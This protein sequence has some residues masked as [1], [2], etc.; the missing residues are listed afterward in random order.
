M[1][2]PQFMIV[3]ILLMFITTVGITVFLV[4]RSNGNAR[5][6][7]FI[8]CVIASFYLIGYLIAPVSA[9]ISLLVL[10][11]M[12][13]EEDNSLVD[14]KDGTFHLISLSAGGLFFVIYGLFAVGGVY[15]LWMAIQLG[16]FW[17]FVVGLFPLSFL[18]SVPV[19]AYSLVFGMPDWVIS[20]FG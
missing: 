15:W 7:W 19:G 9:V 11:L 16:S 14:I 12:K 5:L 18:V 6:Y 3:F 13:N 10:F 20:F 4:K 17:M 1:T 8:A 2:E